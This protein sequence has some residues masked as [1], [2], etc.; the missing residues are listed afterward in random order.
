MP[1]LLISLHF[2][3]ESYLLCNYAHCCFHCGW[4]S[5]TDAVSILIQYFE[6][7][8]LSMFPQGTGT[9]FP[10]YPGTLSC[11]QV[12]ATHL[13]IGHLTWNW[14]LRA[15]QWRHNG[16]DGIS[17]HQYHDCLLNYLFRSK[18]ISKLRVTGLCAGNSPVTGEF[19]TQMASNA[20]NI[21]H[22]MTSPWG[23]RSSNVLRWF[24][25]RLWFPVQLRTSEITR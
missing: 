7:A 22:L 25:L 15:L 13:E 10:G 23:A 19:P 2:Q 5:T 9:F 14:N 18:K 4:I 1:R 11:F 8:Y 16:R 21:F 3:C 6:C 24:D 20:E 17:N 12:S